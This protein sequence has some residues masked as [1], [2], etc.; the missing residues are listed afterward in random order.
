[1]HKQKRYITYRV[2]LFLVTVLLNFKH[3]SAQNLDIDLLKNINGMY[4]PKMGTVMNGFTRS[5]TPISLGLPATFLVYSQFKKDKEVYFS[6]L[7]LLSAQ[8]LSGFAT[9]ALKISVQ[10][11]RPFNAYPNEIIKHTRAG[12]F[13]FPSGHTS[14]AFSTATSISLLY[15]KWYVVIPAYLWASTVAYS[16]MYLG[17]HYPSDVLTGAIIGSGVSLLVHLLLK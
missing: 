11:E 10:R 13:S 6:G 16:R 17:V 5:D 2:L 8:A 9:T 3:G 12:S 7:E 14:M 1:M 15:P 4:S